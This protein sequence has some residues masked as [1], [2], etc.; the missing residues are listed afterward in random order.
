MKCVLCNINQAD[1]T[2][3]HYLTDS[4]IRSCLNQDGSNEREKGYYFDISSNKTF[5]D[6]NFQRKT[7][8]SALEAGLGRVPSE[9]E[10]EK[11]KKVPFSVDHFFCTEC[12]FI[13]SE[14]ENK[15]SSDFLSQFREKDLTG[16]SSLSFDNSTVFRQFFLIQIW[17][18]AVCT[19]FEFKIS[20]ASS[21]MIRQ[22]I[23]TP[24]EAKLKRFPLSITYLTT[25]GGLMEYTKNIVGYTNETTP[26]VIFM[27]DFI[28]QFY[29]PDSKISLKELFGINSADYKTFINLCEN[30]FIV[31]IISND[32]RIK[33]VAAFIQER[34][35]MPLLSRFRELFEEL[36]RKKY[37]IDPSPQTTNMYIQGLVNCGDLPLI[38]RLSIKRV[39]DYTNEFF[40]NYL[41][42]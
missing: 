30:K 24:D 1:K 5:T 42:P 4:I 7:T 26:N 33:I 11:A 28:I 41:Q 8:L 19:N 18:T 36:F 35:V 17:R 39:T 34:K 37:N 9:E 31:K 23:L 16:I 6:F 32:L 25:R 2:N 15:F 3:T 14:I 10:I 29:E 38:E 12:E 40:K 21:E 22:L 27:N 20:N 13:F